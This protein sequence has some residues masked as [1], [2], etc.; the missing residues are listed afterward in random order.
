MF[1]LISFSRL[2]TICF[3][4]YLGACSVALASMDLMEKPETWA[5]IRRIEKAH[6]AFSERLHAHRLV[7]NLR[8]TGVILAFDLNTGT[9][10]SYFNNLRDVIWKFFLDKKLLLRPLG[11]TIYVLPPYCITDDELSVVYEGILSLLDF[12]EMQ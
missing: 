11:N 5:N 1:T 8:Q 10:T 2:L 9:E 6:A 3:A 4:F 12:L 7:K